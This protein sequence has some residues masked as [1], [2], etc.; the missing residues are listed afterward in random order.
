MGRILQTTKDTF[1]YLH[2]WYDDFPELPR[3][4]ILCIAILIGINLSC[5]GDE[6]S[7]LGWVYFGVL[8]ASR[9]AYIK[10]IL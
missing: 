4:W 2:R 1:E 6:T 9:W 8:A 10:G 5:S 3:F 7:F